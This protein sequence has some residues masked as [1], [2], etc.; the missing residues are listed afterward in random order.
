MRTAAIDPNKVYKNEEEAVKDL[1]RVIKGAFVLL[2]PPEKLHV[3]EWADKYRW[4]SSESAS[5]AGPW[6]TSRTPYLKDIMRAFTDPRVRIITVVA[7]S[8]V[9]KSEIQLNCLGYIIDNAPGST[10]YVHPDL[11]VARSFSKQRIEPMLNDCKRLRDKMRTKKKSSSSSTILQKSFPGGMLTIVGTESA[12]ALASTP[13][14]YLIGD[15][16]DR[17]AFDVEGE[18][19]AWELAEARQTTFYNSKALEV[20]TPT[21]AGKS[22]I[23]KS[24]MNGTQ[25][26]WCHKCQEC[27]QYHFI[28]FENIRY[29]TEVKEINGEKVYKAKVLGF[30]CPS[31]GVITPEKVMK[32]QPQKWIMNNP[33]A[34][35]SGHVSFWISPFAHHWRHWRTVVDK[36][37][38]V[39]DDPLKLKTFVNTVLGQPFEDR[40][41]IADE[42][43]LLNRRENYGAELPDGVLAL[44]CGVDTQ[45]NRLEYEVVGHGLFGETWGIEKGCIMGV[46]DTDEVWER[47]DEVIEH[48]YKFKDGKGLKI[49]MT[50]VDSGGHYTN[51][52]Y[53]YCR[54]RFEKNVV[55]IKGKGGDIQYINLPKKAPIRGNKKI[56]TWLYTLGVDSGK[57]TIMSNLKV[58]SAGPKFCHFPLSGNYDKSFF[59]GLLSER[60]VCKKTAGGFKWYWEKIP[61]HVRN[62][63]L[64]CRNYALAAFKIKNPDLQAI[65]MRLKNGQ[66]KQAQNKPKRKKRVVNNP[67]LESDEW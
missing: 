27:G 60:L 52:V 17:W 21:V 31:C 51:E 55:A 65:E 56:W 16:R 23:V 35:E 63:A 15:E 25:A 8:Q 48:V 45:D 18:G 26:Y 22:P 33:D 49:L 39:K 36:F 58:Q 29:E 9:G 59:N 50:C 6:R 66:P 62:E 7:P 37:L 1:N 47:L 30:A 12:R 28:L 67:Y 64:D 13:V 32:R 42:E 20:S 44:T 10:M 41:E 46:P 24:F 2:K 19:D 43:T 40:G 61:G 53:E 57:A 38:A 5:E 34:Y 4:I 11:G 3:D 54:E 14:K